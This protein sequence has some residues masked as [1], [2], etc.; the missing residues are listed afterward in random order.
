MKISKLVLSISAIALTM[1]A[2]A[3]Q[4]DRNIEKERYAVRQQESIVKKQKDIVE[5]QTRLLRQQERKLEDL[6][7]N[8]RREEKKSPRNRNDRYDRPHNSDGRPGH[9]SY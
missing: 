6:R 3:S 1:P 4:Y 7:E 2:F 8:L 5:Q 9:H